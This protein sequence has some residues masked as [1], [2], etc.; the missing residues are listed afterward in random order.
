[1]STAP[2]VI[3]SQADFLK[4]I[5]K[6]AEVP[7]V[8]EPALPSAASAPV[9]APTV[10]PEERL[11][12]IET[13]LGEYSIAL[14]SPLADA[15]RNEILS[16]KAAL[17][18][19][20]FALTHP[21]PAPVAE[22]LDIKAIA[23]AAVAKVVEKFSHPSADALTTAQQDLRE[24]LELESDE[25]PEVDLDEQT[26][27]LNEIDKAEVEIVPTVVESLAALSSP[28]FQGVLLEP[29]VFNLVISLL[30]AGESAP[31]LR[32]LKLAREGK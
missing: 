4:A 32:V 10:N 19:E 11:K 5:R 27:A 30:E 15:V 28:K 8:A 14:D 3:R 13:T 9:T 22:P 31:A 25:E 20:Q 16:R 6:S 21:E 1:M 24:V 12:Q 29:V 2:V 7:P 23:D 18:R 17:V 26:K